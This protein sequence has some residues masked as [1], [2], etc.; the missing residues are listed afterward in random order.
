[1]TEDDF[2]AAFLSGAFG[3]FAGADLLGAAFGTAT[4]AASFFAAFAGVVF[5]GR[6]S[7]V[8]TRN[9]LFP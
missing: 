1:M 2:F 4:L 9:V 8:I 5:C 6:I 7:R 3:A